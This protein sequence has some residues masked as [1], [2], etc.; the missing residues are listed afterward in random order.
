MWSYHFIH[1]V[2]FAVL[3]MA[4][5]G[6]YHAFGGTNTQGKPYIYSLIDWNNPGSAGLYAF[7]FGVVLVIGLWFIL[8]GL[9]HVRLAI[10]RATIVAVEDESNLKVS[11]NG[12]GTENGIVNPAYTGDKEDK[13][14]ESP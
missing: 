2:I 3:Y 12:A 7:I 1:T 9:H 5:T 11:D 14:R 10:Y 4:F 8:F 6:V 13:Y